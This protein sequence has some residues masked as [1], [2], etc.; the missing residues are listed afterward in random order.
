MKVEKAH[1]LVGIGSSFAG[2]QAFVNATLAQYYGISP[3]DYVRLVQVASGLPQPLYPCDGQANLTC[4]QANTTPQIC[5]PI[6]AD[7][8]VASPDG[9][10]ALL[11]LFPFAGTHQGTTVFGAPDN[12]Y[13][14]HDSLLIT[15]LSETV[16]R[17]ALEAV[18]P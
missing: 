18:F 10:G 4:I 14:H 11:V 16:M 9:C 2:W 3:G 17:T 12:R 6:V 13:D 7:G 8:K 5:L 1:S 15:G